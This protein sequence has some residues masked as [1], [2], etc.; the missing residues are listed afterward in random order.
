[1]SFTPSDSDHD[2]DVEE[3]LRAIL[4]ELQ[5]MNARLEEAYETEI[6]DEDMTDDDH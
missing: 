2:L 5:L 3:V 4:A 6:T 1:M